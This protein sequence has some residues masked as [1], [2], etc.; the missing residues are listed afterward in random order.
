[1]R[2]MKDPIKLLRQRQKGRSLTDFAKEIPCSASYLCDVYAGRREPADRI[3]T[4]L[5]LE[6]VVTYRPQS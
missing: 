3:L 4:Y 1:M 5:K 6:R 2:R